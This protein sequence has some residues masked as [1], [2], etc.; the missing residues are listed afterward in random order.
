[1]TGIP[2]P[3]VTEMAETLL[4][5]WH[6]ATPEELHAGLHWYDRAR[7]FAQ[8]LA[9]E[10][11]VPVGVAACVIAAHSQNCRWA[12]NK[13]RA[14]AQL[15]GSPVGLGVAIRAAEAAIAH[16]RSPYRW[17]TG[18]KLHPFARCVG[19]DLSQVACDRWAQ[20]IA[21][22]LTAPYDD[23]LCSALIKRKGARADMTVAYQ[24]AAAEVGVES[25]IMQ[26]TVWCVIRGNDA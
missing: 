24:K 5:V 15:A 3:T 13:N 6:A 14:R 4:T 11:K 1:M 22:G 21:Y 16:P 17:I 9:T 2:S 18:P 12:E 20:R 7:G 10:F 26:A 8:E 23:R 25:A 19:G